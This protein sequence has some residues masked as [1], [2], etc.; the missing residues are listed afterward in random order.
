[1][2]TQP[3]IVMEW[4]NGEYLFALR[5]AQIEALEAECINPDTGKG[6][7]GIAA[8]FSR[9]MGMSWYRSDLTNI[10]RL[11][12]IGGGMGA[13]EALRLVRD[14]AETVPLSSL[15][16]GVGANS[17]LTVAQAVITA[18]VAGI[19]KSDETGKETETPGE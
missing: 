11:G 17:P 10:I 19:P 14:Y 8:I 7:I 3:E 13:V 1:M 12:L 18:A 4:A 9:L 5:G 6:G 15:T 2:V 16:P